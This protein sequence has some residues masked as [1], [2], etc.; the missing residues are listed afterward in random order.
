MFN[1]YGNVR[2]N[3][4]HFPASLSKIR[5]R[6]DESTKIRARRLHNYWSSI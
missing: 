3:G 5:A 6:R 4:V 1:T 2:Q